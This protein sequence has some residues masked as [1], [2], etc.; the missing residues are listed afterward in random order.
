MVPMVWSCM[1]FYFS[2]FIDYL[3]FLLPPLPS[4]SVA[5]LWINQRVIRLQL[6]KLVVPLMIQ[7]MQ[8]E[9]YVKLN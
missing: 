6:R 7:L 5:L 3:I 1:F 8:K 2:P 9:Y 4:P